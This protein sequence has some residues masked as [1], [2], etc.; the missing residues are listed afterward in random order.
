MTGEVHPHPLPWISARVRAKMPA[1]ERPMP[2][3]SSPP[4]VARRC[5]GTKVSTKAIPAAPIG[6]LT[7]KIQFHDAY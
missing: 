2:S 3:G 4:R 7:K 1:A 5:S 6:T